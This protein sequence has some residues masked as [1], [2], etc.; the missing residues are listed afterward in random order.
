MTEENLRPQEPQF[1]YPRTSSMAVFSLVLGIASYVVIPLLGAIAAII[2]GNLAK[3]EIQ[4]NPEVLTGEGLARWGMILGWVNVGI[5][6]IG[7]CVTL[8]VV[9][10]TVLT[11]LGLIS[12]PLL[13]IPLTNGG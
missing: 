4:E 5:S 12:L 10:M 1:Y 9:V 3:K 11:A 7:L 13:L 6:I 2:T 8:A